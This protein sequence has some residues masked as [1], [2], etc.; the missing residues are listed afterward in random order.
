MQSSVFRRDSTS[1]SGL[2]L[3]AMLGCC[4]AI[5]C[6]RSGGGRGA[7]AVLQYMP[8]NS[9]VVMHINV[10]AI[11]ESQVGKDMLA[12]IAKLPHAGDL[13]EEIDEEIKDDFGISLSNLESV[14]MGGRPPNRG[15]EEFVAVLRLNEAVDVNSVLDDV[16]MPDWWDDYSA[17]TSEDDEDDVERPPKDRKRWARSEEVKTGTYYAG[18][19]WSED[20]AIWFPNDRTLV[21]G[22]ATAIKDVQ[23]RNGPAKVSERLARRL[24]GINFDRS[25]ALAVEMPQEAWDELQ[26]EAEREVPWLSMRA[27]ES[28]QAGS[29]EITAGNDVEA[30]AT[31]EFASEEIAA[32]AA[33][34]AEGAVAMFKHVFELSDDAR[35]T[36]NAIEIT[37]SGGVV[38]AELTVPGKTLVDSF[39]NVAET[40]VESF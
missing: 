33:E 3:V 7:A 17:P 32:D 27:I 34:I 14:T 6:G 23:K 38:K 16:L 30:T 37:A 10:T 40:I 29:L 39:S 15:P 8:D 36:L 21:Y 18:R 13:E 9:F 11:L 20:E 35:K 4:L 25:F 24:K 31:I 2:V 19:G 22:S 28:F 1:Q 5:G 12:A 26:E